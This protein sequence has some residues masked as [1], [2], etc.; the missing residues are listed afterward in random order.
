MNGSRNDRCRYRWPGRSRLIFAV[1]RVASPDITVFVKDGNAT[2]P[3]ASRHR[4]H[5]TATRQFDGLRMTVPEPPSLD[6]APSKA[7]RCN[8]ESQ[9]DHALKHVN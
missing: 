2:F 3:V 4:Y 7:E 5:S 9:Q 8:S 1:V 6:I